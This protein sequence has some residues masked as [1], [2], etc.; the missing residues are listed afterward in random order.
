VGREVAEG[1]FVLGDLHQNSAIVKVASCSDDPSSRIQSDVRGVI[2][3]HGLACGNF[4]LRI[5]ADPS[6]VQPDGVKRFELFPHSWDVLEID[7]QDGVPFS[8]NLVHQHQSDS[9]GGV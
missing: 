8:E 5:A 1:L 2:F 7:R 3:K 9:H 4:Y 6:D